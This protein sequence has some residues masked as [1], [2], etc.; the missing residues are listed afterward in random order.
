VVSYF[1]PADP[2]AAQPGA[3]EQRLLEIP[4]TGL[5]DVVPVAAWQR[6]PLAH[7]LPQ[8][9]TATPRAGCEPSFTLDLLGHRRGGFAPTDPVARTEWKGT[10]SYASVRLG[11]DAPARPGTSK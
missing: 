10:L 5:P 9:F 6:L 3:G 11:S 1:G 8:F 7:P 2:A 4:A